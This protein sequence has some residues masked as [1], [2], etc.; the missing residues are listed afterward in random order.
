MP[1]IMYKPNPEL[2]EYVIW[3]T[4]AGTPLGPV[5]DRATAKETWRAGGCSTIG[6]PT[7]EEQ[8]EEA[9]KL[10]DSKG[11][12]NQIFDCPEDVLLYIC[13]IFDYPGP[14]DSG[15]CEVADLAYITRAIEVRDWDTV[16]K[17]LTGKS[18]PEEEE[19]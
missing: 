5:M 6:S 15:L 8:A 3:S 11:W 12:S 1:R 13:N 2:D 18:R 4:V 14:F 10:A 9:M 17:L 7:S 16:H 19:D